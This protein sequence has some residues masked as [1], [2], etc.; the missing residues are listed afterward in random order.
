[1]APGVAEWVSSL[2]TLLTLLT[3]LIHTISL[4]TKAKEK[5]QKGKKGKKEIAVLSLPLRPS[6][7]PIAVPTKVHTYCNSVR[8]SD[9]IAGW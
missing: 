8:A 7:T 3:S 1:M 4:L 2:L 5:R 6:G 9:A